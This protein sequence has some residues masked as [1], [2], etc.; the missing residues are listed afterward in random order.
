MEH[1]KGFVQNKVEI[2]RPQQKYEAEKSL[3]NKEGT[4]VM[5]S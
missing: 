2:K 5:H 1:F 4:K 3:K